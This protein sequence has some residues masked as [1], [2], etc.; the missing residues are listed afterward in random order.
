MSIG[1]LR[2]LL[3]AT[4]AGPII[5]IKPLLQVLKGCWHDFDGSDSSAMAGYKL[6]RMERVSWFP[7]VLTF[8]VERHGGVMMGSTRAELQEWTVDLV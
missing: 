4:T 1:D 7:P 5:N 6:D 2:D 8:T 3:G